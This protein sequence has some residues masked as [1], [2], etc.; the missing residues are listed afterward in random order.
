[1][2]NQTCSHADC[3][4]SVD[5]ELHF[6]MYCPRFSNTRRHFFANAARLIPG[7]SNMNDDHK[8]LT[9]LCPTSAQAAK[10]AN[11]FIKFMFEKRKRIDF[12]ENMYEL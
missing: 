3:S 8:F 7:F 4:G 9:L 2:P 12:G 11:R 10:L 5:S 1:M 6:L